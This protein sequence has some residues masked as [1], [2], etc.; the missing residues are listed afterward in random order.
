MSLV[1]IIFMAT[2]IPLISCRSIGEQYYTVPNDT[3]TCAN[4]LVIWCD[5]TKFPSEG[6]GTISVVAVT[7][8][9]SSGYCQAVCTSDAEGTNCTK[10]GD[11][12]LTCTNKNQLLYKGKPLTKDSLDNT[13][14][15]TCE[16]ADKAFND[17]FV[18]NLSSDN[19]TVSKELES[20]LEQL[21]RAIAAMQQRIADIQRGFWGTG[22]FPFYYNP[23]DPNGSGFPDAER[24]DTSSAEEP[25]DSREKE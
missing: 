14:N 4:D 9:D 10:N 18:Q 15:S 16:T 13:D 2:T 25:E 7:I 20:G 23:F 5:G 12:W 21:Y 3:Q 8:I 19:T 24:T 17:L 1:E 6:G 22:G 11:P